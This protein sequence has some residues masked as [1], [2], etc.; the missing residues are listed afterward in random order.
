MDNLATGQINYVIFFTFPLVAGIIM[1]VSAFISYYNP[2]GPIL[3]VIPAMMMAMAGSNVYYFVDL[4][5]VVDPSVEI[6]VT[7]VPMSM[8]IFGVVALLSIGI[9]EKE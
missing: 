7:A 3:S 1:I 5:R 9:R 8:V 6:S 2:K 4:A